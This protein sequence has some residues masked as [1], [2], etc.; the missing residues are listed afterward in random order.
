MGC[1]DLIE[2]NDFDLPDFQVNK[3]QKKIDKGF[4]QNISKHFSS[5]II[6]K[7][8]SADILA[9][10]T[11]KSN[12]YSSDGQTVTFS[13]RTIESRSQLSDL[14]GINASGGVFKTSFW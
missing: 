10:I 6:S 2:Q 4:K 3:K 5:C 8:S 1:S 12:D 14:M 7:E 13:H 11:N 9:N